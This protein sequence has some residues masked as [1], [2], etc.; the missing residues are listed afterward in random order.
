M[1]FSQRLKELRMAR[2][3]SQ[4][5]F[6]KQLGVSAS[7]V[8]MY[9]CGQREPSFEIEERIADFFNVDLDYLRG[10]SDTTSKIISGDAHLLLHI[11]KELDEVS[12][13]MLLSYAR[14]MLDIKY[15]K[16]KMTNC[17]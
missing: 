4:A 17:D 12:Q 10:G 15:E 3:L 5:Q 14:G 1:T 2:N 13:K 6:A 9:E 11:Y 16:Q 7:A 8:S